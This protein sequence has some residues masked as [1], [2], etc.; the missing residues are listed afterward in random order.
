LVRPAPTL[1]LPKLTAAHGSE[2]DL[3]RQEAFAVIEH[4]HVEILLDDRRMVLA[5][6]IFRAQ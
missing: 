2:V 4:L 1:T 5:A 3:S 6:A